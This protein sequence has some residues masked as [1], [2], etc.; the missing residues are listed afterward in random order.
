MKY[1]RIKSLRIENGLKQ[2]DVAKKLKVAPSNYSRWEIGKEIIPLSKLNTLCNLYEI[3]MN[4]IV[5]LSNEKQFKKKCYINSIKVGK[6]LKKLRKDYNL[7]QEELASFLNTTHSTIS[8]YENG[9]T[10]ILTIYA[11]KICAKYNISMDWLCS[12]Q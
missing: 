2:K 3:N 12:R 8:A 4:Y 7:T 11:Y 5:G 9:K 10:M 1:S 6:K